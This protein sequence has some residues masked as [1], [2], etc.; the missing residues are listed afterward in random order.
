MPEHTHASCRFR[1]PTNSGRQIIDSTLDLFD[2]AADRS[3]TLRRLTVCADNVVSENS[4]S[5][6]LTLFSDIERDIKE[7]NLQLMELSIKSR[8]GK[9]AVLKGISFVEGATMRERNDQVG[10]HK[11]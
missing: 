8:F 3:L 9:N 1:E 5:R 7:R 10:G 11:A 4:V 6:Q 2:K